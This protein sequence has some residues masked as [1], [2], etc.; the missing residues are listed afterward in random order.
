[1]ATKIKMIFWKAENTCCWYYSNIMLGRALWKQGIFACQTWNPCHLLKVPITHYPETG[2][3]FKRW[4]L[5]LQPIILL[6]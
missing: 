4:K 5:R 2:T 3:K 6:L 1:M